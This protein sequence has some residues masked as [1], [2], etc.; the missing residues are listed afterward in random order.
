MYDKLLNL[1]IWR[2]VRFRKMG[3]LVIA[4]ISSNVSLVMNIVG[5]CAGFLFS[6]EQGLRDWSMKKSSFRMPN[7]FSSFRDENRLC[8]LRVD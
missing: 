8:I 2:L 4:V 1:L 5:V 7:D 6:S 3:R